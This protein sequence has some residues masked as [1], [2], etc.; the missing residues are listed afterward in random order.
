MTKKSILITYRNT[1]HKIFHEMWILQQEYKLKSIWRRLRNC[2][3]V[4]GIELCK[5]S[6]FLNPCNQ[7]W[8]DHQPILHMAEYI[9]P[10][11]MLRFCDI[12]LSATY[13]LLFV[14]HSILESH[15]KFIF[16]REVNPYASEW[17]CNSKIKRS[18]VKITQNQNVIW[19]FFAHV[20]VKPRPKWSPAH[21]TDIIE[22]ISPVK[23]LLFVICLSV[24]LSVTYLSFTNYWKVVE[25]IYFG[26]LPITLVNGR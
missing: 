2:G 1:W 11:E 18:E 9:S 25:S 13:V 17:W 5:I 14:Y 16:F 24:Y 8:N 21:S 26:N 19:S 7:N 15:R 23:M 20:Y 22:Y 10:A 12:C 6:L 3:S 4:G